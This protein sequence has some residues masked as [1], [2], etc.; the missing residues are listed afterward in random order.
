MH[1]ASAA[2]IALA[3]SASG[4]ALYFPPLSSASRPYSALPGTT[5]HT[6]RAMRKWQQSRSRLRRER[7]MRLSRR[8]VRADWRCDS[9][10]STR[11][12]EWPIQTS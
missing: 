6:P 8:A 4:S 3:L 12:G 1:S 11:Q 7:A 10:D 2:G 5:F 9:F